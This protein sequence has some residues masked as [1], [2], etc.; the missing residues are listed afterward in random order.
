MKTL[1]LEKNKRYFKGLS[2]DPKRV[3]EELSEMQCSCENNRL[4]DPTSSALLYLRFV[5]NKL[6]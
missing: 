4:L 1:L 5:G 3:F 6:K 2:K